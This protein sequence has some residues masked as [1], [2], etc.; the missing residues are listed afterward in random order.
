MPFLI[1]TTFSDKE[2]AEKIAC[3][4]LEK[5]LIACANIFAP[6]TSIYKWE[7]KVQSETEIAAILKTEE[8]HFDEI[9]RVIKLMHSYDTPAIIGWKADKTA[10]DFAKWIESEIQ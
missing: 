8:K 7:G 10:T 3:A 1:Y 2:Q 6:H 5:K 9:E 4:L